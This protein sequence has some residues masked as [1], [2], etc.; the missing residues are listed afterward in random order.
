[1]CTPQCI[2]EKLG[3]LGFEEAIKAWKYVRHYT[4]NLQKLQVKLRDLGDCTETITREVSEAI[5]RDDEIEVS[6]SH[7]QTDADNLKVDIEQLIGESTTKASISCIACSCPNIMWRYKFSKQAEEKMAYAV[8]LIGKC[9]NFNHQISHP[10]SHYAENLQ[11]LKDKLRD[12]DDCRGTITIKVS[13]AYG[14]GDEIE[15]NVSRWQ[16]YADSLKADIEQLISESTNMCSNEFPDSTWQYKFSKQ[17]EDRIANADALITNCNNFNHQISHPRPRPPEL[18]SL[19]DKNYVNFDSRASIFKDIMDALKD[20]NVNMI[21]VFGLGGVGKTTLVKEVGEQMRKDGTFKQVAM[22]VVSKD[23]NVKEVQSKLADSLNFEFKAK[24]DDQKRRAT[25]LWNKLANGDKYLIILDD[26]W[27]QVKM[28]AIGIPCTNK[29]KGCKVVF[30]SRNEDLLSTIMEVDR[31]FSMAILSSAE[32]WTL[33]MKKVGNSIESQPK[34]KSLAYEVCKRCKGLPVAINALGEALKGKQEHAWQTALDKLD[35]YMLTKIEGVHP[36]VLASL[37][38]SYDMLHSADAKSC[39]LLCCLFAED[40]EIPIDELMRLCVARNLLDQNPHTLDKAR[41][42]V[43]TVVDILKSVSLLTTGSHETV[44]KI[45]DVIRDVGISIAREEEAFLVDHGAL[46]WPRNPTDGPLYKAM[47]LSFKNIK[48]LPDG[49]VY[50]RIHTLMVENTKLSDL[51]VGDNF[52]NGMTQLAVLTFTRMRMQ[53]LPSSLA[54]LTNLKM[55]YL[56]KCELIDIA[57]LKDLKSNLEV[58]SLRGSSIKV[59]PPETGQL[60]GLRV[61]DLQ[62][63]GKLMVIPRGVISNLTSLEELYF[64]MTFDKWGATTNEQ[65]DTSSSDNASLEE[66]GESLARSQLTTLHIH[67]PNVTLLPKE[68]LKFEKLKRFRISVGS[69]FDYSEALISRTC[70]LKLEGIQLRNEF[71]P[72]VEKAEVLVLKPESSVHPLQLF[73]ELTVLIIEH[74]K[75]K[76]LFS[77]TTARGLV[78]LEVLEVTSCEIMKGIVGFE[79]QKDENEVTGEVKFSKLKQLKLRSLPNLISF[80]AKKEEM[81]TTMGSFSTRAQPLFNEQV[82]FPVLERLTI[83]GLGKIIKIWDK[84]LVAVWQEQGSFCQLTYVNIKKCE[85]LMHVFPSNMH[86]LLKNLEELEVRECETMKGIAEFEGERDEDGVRNEVASPTREHLE[87]VGVTEIE[88]KQPLPESRK[89]VE[90]LCRPLNNDDIIVFPRLKTVTLWTLPKLKSFYSETQGIFSHKSINYARKLTNNWEALCK[91]ASE[92]RS[93][94]DDIDTEIERFRLQ[95]TPTHECDNWRNEVAEMENKVATLQQEFNV[96]KN[97]VWGLCP[98]IFYRIKLVERRPNPTSKLTTSAYDTRVIVLNK[99]RDER[100]AKIGIWGVGGVGKTAILQLLNNYYH[101]KTFFDLVIWVTVSKSLSIRN[102]QNEVGMRL[103]IEI[104]VDESD[105][106]IARTLFRCLEGKKY[107]LLLDDVWDEV[108]LSIVGFP[109]ANQQNGCKVVLTTRKNEVCRKMKTVAEVPI[110]ILPNEEA[111]E[112]F[113]SGVGHVSTLS[114]IKTYAQ[115][116]VSECDGLPLALKVICGALRKEENVYVWKN[117]LR[118]LKSPATS[119]IRDLNDKVFKVLKVSY[120]QLKN[121]EEKKCLLFC[122]LYPEDDMIEKSRLIGYWRAERIFSGKLTLEQALDKGEA[123]FQALIDASLLEKCDKDDSVKMHDVVRDMVLAI[124]SLQGEE[125]T[126]LVRAGISLEM[127]PEEVEWKNATRISFMNRDLRSLPESPNC[128]KLLTLLL[129]GNENLEVIPETF[130]NNMPS[131]RVLDL[132]RTHIKSLPTSISKLDG[133]RELVLLDCEHLEALPKQ[134]TALKELEVL[135]VGRS[136]LEI[137]RRGMKSIELIIPVGMICGIPHIE[138]IELTSRLSDESNLQHFLQNSIPWKEKRLTQFIFLAGK[139]PNQLYEYDPWFIE[140]GKKYKRFLGYE[141]GG[142]E[143]DNGLPPAIEDILIR[144]NGFLLSRHGKL[145]ALSELGT[146]NTDELRFCWI[147]ECVA[148][149]T[150]VDRNGL[151]MSAF[152]NLEVLFLNELS[153]LKSIL[154]LEMEEGQSS[155]PPPPL[156]VNSFTNLTRLSIGNCPLIEHLFSSGFMLQQMSNLKELRVRDCRGLK[157]MILEDE[158]LE[159]EALPKLS[160]LYLYRLPEFVNLF[161]GVPMCWQSLDKVITYRTPKLRKLPFDTNSAPNLKGVMGDDE[162][163]W[164][165]LEWDNHAAKLQLLKL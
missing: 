81:R 23:L 164:D 33:F 113:S 83:D 20:S 107:L 165:A 46:R 77:P 66:L 145:K 67:V 100:T 115:D 28:E 63:C 129:Q 126:H 70:M 43:R 32:A 90:S 104:N 149:E 112:M 56:N 151:E 61:L 1:M 64:P 14:R 7:W 37:R 111:W 134:I 84:Q 62:D 120:D 118:D 17:A 74:F 31:N 102:L 88:D 161:G 41:N 141:G 95:R 110:S 147:E 106:R 39:F 97:C 26:I 130:F 10:R 154:C 34:I 133:L 9:N 121:T 30:T 40:A 160:C 156:N 55:L 132:S 69:K 24:A 98:D 122:G 2:C 150:I 58:L 116:I 92:L 89:E 71:I 27:E 59:L 117:F 137:G 159:Y 86:P 50:P 29:K 101:D 91:K 162:E 75:L 51:E 119:V 53:R 13:E 87:M 124:T 54:K 96:E 79:G 18:E 93:K 4:E 15:V 48:G 139:C 109:T 5:G 152:S 76:Y 105:D 148:P 68:D 35:K 44:V 114:T 36:S 127:I 16:T 143:R 38:V 144:S 153:N 60:T 57:V 128:P 140:R 146:E 21:G 82:I 85:K 155:S 72:L 94:K 11:K 163:W 157:G 138:V 52:F 142:E 125:P 8:E 6:V 3:G 80:F 108:D 135:Y 25:E 12:L 49:L 42:A 123:I 78:H 73:N 103:S 158:K 19:S 131:L 22:A 136:N 99:L 45:H 47:S 65:Q